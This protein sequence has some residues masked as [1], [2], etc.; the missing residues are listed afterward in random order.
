MSI[1][2]P[3]E[4]VQW[5]LFAAGQVT[6][7]TWRQGL[8]NSVLQV[9]NFPLCPLVSWLYHLKVLRSLRTLPEPGISSSGW[10]MG[11]CKILWLKLLFNS[12]KS[13]VSLIK[14]FQQHFSCDSHAVTAVHDLW[15]S[16]IVKIIISNLPHW[17]WWGCISSKIMQI[18]LKGEG[19]PPPF[20]EKEGVGPSA[21]SDRPA[22]PLRELKGRV[23]LLAIEERGIVH[24]M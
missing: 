15:D 13:E 14:R 18:F 5:S 10:S 11:S 3:S 8:Q 9:C 21:T 2:P 16:Q 20:R 22:S 23:Q 19:T 7:G 12:E 1:L 17:S 4:A 24:L 6:C